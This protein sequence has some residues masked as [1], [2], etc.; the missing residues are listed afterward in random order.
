MP[1]RSPRPQFPG[2][3]VTAVL[4]VHDGA[5]WLPDCLAALA[6]QTRPPQRVVA[7]DTRSADGA[8]GLLPGALGE[9]AVVPMPRDTG[10]G[11][12][13]QAGLD[14]FIGAPAPPGPR[15]SAGTEWVWVLHDDCAPD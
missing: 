12:A 6:A 2:H 10:L 8:V 7:V 14:A 3:N 4:V 9:A 15:G 13:I 11:D 5:R 1:P